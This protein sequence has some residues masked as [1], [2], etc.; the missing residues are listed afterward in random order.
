MGSTCE[1]AFIA[2]CAKCTAEEA[3]LRRLASLAG[4]ELPQALSPVVLDEMLYA[5][6]WRPAFDMLEKAGQWAPWIRRA[7]PELA[8]GKGAESPG[9]A[10]FFIRERAIEHGLKAEIIDTFR[11]KGFEP[12]LVLELDDAQRETAARAF[13]G[14]NWGASSWHVSGGRPACIVVGLDLLPLDLEG[15][16]A[17]EFPDCDNWKIIRAKVAARDLVNADLP[18][19]GQYNGVHS[20]DNTAQSWRAI[21]L[22]APEEEARLRQEIE[23]HRLAFQSDGVIRD[24]TRYGSRARVALIDFD[25]GLAIRKTFRPTALRYMEREIE[26]ME[27]LAPIC[28]EIPKLL[29]RGKDYIIVEYVGESEPLPPWPHPLPLKIVR[30]LARFVQTCVSNGFDPIDMKPRGNVL[31]TASGLKVIDYEFWRRCD[32]STRPEQS[33]CLAGL[34]RDYRGDRP[35]GVMFLFNP[36]PTQW[37]RHTGLSLESFLYDPAWLQ[38][39]RRS[40]HLTGRYGRWII[41]GILR[42]LLRGP[43]RRAKRALLT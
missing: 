16:L 34:P 3:E 6:G 26:V 24:L 23:E 22:L 36:Y 7:F 41:K 42:R 19:R 9:V 40:A 5:E 31:L 29:S 14:G 27:T 18:K 11:E 13:R 39:I 20:T 33:Y 43:L 10:V 37:F 25:G 2:D 12:L 30:Q 15:P 17:S 1:D 4:F 38:L 32:P 28:T 35:R 21:R 8:Q